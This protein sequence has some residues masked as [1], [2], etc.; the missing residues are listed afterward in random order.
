MDEL[1]AHLSE[2]LTTG[3][4]VTAATNAIWGGVGLCMSIGLHLLVKYRS[5]LLPSY[6]LDSF[7]WGRLP[8]LCVWLHRSYWN[9][10]IFLAPEGRSYAP[11]FTGNKHWLSFLILGIVIG[12]VK[13]TTPF[14][15]QSIKNKVLSLV[16]SFL[17]ASALV[18]A[19]LALP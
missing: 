8:G 6:V 4:S 17:I 10:A 13:A 16:F 11:F 1:L 18:S 15:D 12:T 5:E 7:K 14:I 9:C 19:Y 3:S 2:M